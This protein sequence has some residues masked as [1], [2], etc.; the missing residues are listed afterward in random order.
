M[1]PPVEV[2]TVIAAPAAV[3][4]EAFL[5]DV[6]AWWLG[7]PRFRR[8]PEALSVMVLEPYVGG[9]LLETY[10]DQD[11]GDAVWAH[12]ADLRAPT[13]EEDGLLE[14]SFLE[15]GG[16]A[17]RV[18][19]DFQHDG[20]ETRVRVLHGDWDHYP[21]GHPIYRGLDATGFASLIG[22][23]WADLLRAAGR[24][25]RSDRARNEEVNP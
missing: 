17:T 8:A 25:V 19:V 23:W 1:I 12:V 16:D 5:Q 15:P 18:R 13:A 20:G 9:R 2:Q 22:L 21:E 11:R 10:P 4:F 3:T 6:D 7:G 14:L 24:H